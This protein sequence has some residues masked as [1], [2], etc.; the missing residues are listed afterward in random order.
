MNGQA[1]NKG[2]YFHQHNMIISRL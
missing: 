1:D 2:S